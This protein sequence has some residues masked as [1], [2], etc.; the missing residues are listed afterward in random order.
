M[1]I[2]ESFSMAL[3][4]IKS[5]K[6]RSS[7]TLL[8]IIVGVFSIICVMTA[9]NALQNAI[10]GGLSQLG[11]NTFQVQKYPIG[12]FGPM[13]RSRYR[14]RKDITLD[15]GLEVKEKST[16][17]RYV[18]LESWQAGMVIKSRYKETN[19]NIAVVGENPEGLITN[20]WI[21]HEG[22]GITDQDLELNRRVAVVGNSV[23]EKLFPYSDPV[24]EEIKIDGI[25]YTVIGY[26]EQQGGFLGGNQ[27]NF[28]A[29]P[30]TT[31]MQKYRYGYEGSI[32]IMVQA[33]SR[34]L[35]DATIDEVTSILRTVR[36]ISPGKPSDFEIFSNETLIKQ[37]N[38]LTVY[39][40]I[41]MAFIS[42][43]ALLAAGVGIMNIMLVSVTE[44]T[45]EIGIRK[46]IGARRR[47]I[48]SQFLLEA[49]I[50]CELGG[51][52]GII[53]GIAVGDLLS[54]MLN[55]PPVIPVDWIIFGLVICSVVGITFG[56]YPAWKASK[57]DPVESL[58]YE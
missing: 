30:L 51:V 17:A 43:I 53:A 7:L 8:G 40:K 5:N 44:R 27:D 28:I 50:L 56:V 48:L 38:D 19:P 46:S 33:K 45:R 4:A 29:I 1:E 36:K 39:V 15:Q 12:G 21:V 54:S 55:A 49:V 41:G 16:L 11:T 20:N 2:K 35:Y 10:E 26:L 3:A 23:V 6:L 57:L 47:N 9:M 34:E 42:F 24:G 13:D 52:I 31:F 58:R 14:N 18:G 25:R 22:R 32:H 37:F